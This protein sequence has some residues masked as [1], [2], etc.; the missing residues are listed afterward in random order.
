MF[1]SF[2]YGISSVSYTRDSPWKLHYSIFLYQLTRLYPVSIY[3]FWGEKM[4]YKGGWDA[5]G[6]VGEV[7]G[8]FLSRIFFTPWSYRPLFYCEL[9]YLVLTIILHW[10]K[11]IFSR[12]IY[13][14]KILVKY[15]PLCFYNRSEERL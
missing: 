15:A 12:E 1:K 4:G 5:Q 8:N 14:P 7:K 13:S 10:E 9:T 3:V 11:V 2:C 6:V